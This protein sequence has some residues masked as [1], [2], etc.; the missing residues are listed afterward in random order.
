M[1]SK[2]VDGIIDLILSD[3]SPVTP[4]QQ[5]DVDAFDAAVEEGQ[6]RLCPNVA[7]HT[8]GQPAGYGER[9]KWA[10]E[11]G[12]THRQTKCPGCD[13]YVI[14]LPTQTIDAGP[15]HARDR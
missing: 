7:A 8:P 5:P 14:W 1:T 4:E 3:T 12:R 10:M 11:M 6:R 15:L 9:A 13:L 2:F